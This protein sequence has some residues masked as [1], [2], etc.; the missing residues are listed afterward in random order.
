MPNPD[1][2]QQGRVIGTAINNMGNYS[3]QAAARANN[4]S[5]AS[6]SAQGAFNQGSA[7]IANALGTDRLAEQ[8]AF[9]SA[10]ST[11][12]NNFTEYMW[13][14]S[15]AFN[16]EMLEKQM[17]FNAEQA[18]INRE[19]Q[20]Q[21]RAT[22]YQTAVK[23]METAG[24]NPILAVTGG[25]IQTGA[26]SGGAASASLPQM[27]GAQGA[28]AS[29]GLLNGIAASEGNF[30]GQMEYMGGMLG[31]VSMVMSGFSSA[32]KGLGS[33]GDF[34]EGLGNALADI[35]KDDGKTFADSWDK[36]MDDVKNKP[37]YGMDIEAIRGGSG[38][39]AR[40]GKDRKNFIPF[41]L[42]RNK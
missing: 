32:L 7:N 40:A 38:E 17:E 25:G 15:A 11:G 29:G 39:G 27:S 34:G 22:A 30:Q 3:A 5:F 1:L 9:N 20:E 41:M 2:A 26:G 14:K 42:P 35:L 28:M 6:Q 13:D 37:Y 8:Y 21:M 16:R 31:L 36:A 33:L 23:D 4:I 19:W 24:L 18:K 10:Q 12:A